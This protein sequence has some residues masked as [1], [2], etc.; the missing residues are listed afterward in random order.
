M[1]QAVM[2]DDPAQRLPLWVFCLCICQVSEPGVMARARIC[3]LAFEGAHPRGQEALTVF[4]VV[5][6]V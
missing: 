3:P 4:L 5:G 2:G 1:S 6:P